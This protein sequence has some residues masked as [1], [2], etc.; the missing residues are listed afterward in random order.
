MKNKKT[1]VII[2]FITLFIPSFVFAQISQISFTTTNQIIEPDEISETITVQ[3]QDSGGNLAQTSET[4]DLEFLSSSLTG[5]FLSPSSENPVTTTMASGTANKNFRYRDSSE[6]TFTLTINAVGRVSGSTWSVSQDITVGATEQPPPAVSISGHLATSTTWSAGN[7]YVLEDIVTVPLGTTLTIEPGAIIKG[8]HG[9]AGKLEIFGTLYAQGS[10]EAPIYFTSYLDDEAGGDTD[11]TGTTTLPTAKDWVGVYFKS[12]STGT[13]DHVLV[14]Y[15][16]Y[17][18]AGSNS[19]IDNEGTLTISNSTISDNYIRGVFSSGSLTI[20]DSIFKNQQ[21]GIQTTAGVID[22]RNSTISNNSQYGLDLY[23]V[24][25]TTIINN[26]F[27]GNGKTARI[28]AS[29]AFIHSGNTSSDIEN[30]GFEMIGTVSGNVNWQSGDLPLIIPASSMLWISASSS[31]TINPGTVLKFGES[32]QIIVEGSLVAEGEK[33]SRIYFTSLKDD[34]LMGDTNGDASGT[35]ATM[36]DWTGIEF[37]IGATGNI[38]YSNIY[39]TGRFNGVTRAAVFN[40]GGEATLDNIEFSQNYDNDI[41]QSSGSTTVTNSIFSGINVYAVRHT[42][43]NDIDARLNWW[44]DSTGPTHTTNATGTGSN[45]SDK[46]TFDPWLKRD[47][48]LPNPVII[49]PGIASSYLVTNNN[50]NLEIW[51]N[52]SQMLVSITDSYLDELALSVSGSN[53]GV[54]ITPNGIIKQAG[55]SNFFEGLFEILNSVNSD[56]F[57]F[58]YDWRLDIKTLAF[59]LD[60][61][62]KEIKLQTGAD[63]VD[64]VAHSMGGLLAKEYL[65]NYGGAS[66]DK[67]IDLGTP[68]TGAPKAFK[69]LNYGD[70]FDASFLFGIFGL[71]RQKVK[72]ISQNMPSVYQ[73][74]PSESYFDESDPNYR[75]YVWNGIDGNDRLT[76]DETLV[77]M[78]AEGR[79]ELLLNRAQEFHEEVDG[80]NPSGYGVDT[81]NIVGCG[82]PTLGQFYILGKEGDKYIY[83]IKMINGDGTVPL[84][85]AEALEATETYYVKNAQ[86]ALMPSTSGVKELVASLLKDESLNI[87][88]YPNLAMSVSGCQIP[89]GKLVSFHSPIELHIYDGSGNHVGP[90]EN[91]DIVNEIDGVIYEVI[92]DNKFAYL[93]EGIEYTIKGSATD[94]GI[95]DTRIQEIVDG[96]VATT[97]IFADMPLTL[98]TQVSFDLGIEIPEQIYLDHDGDEVFETIQAISTTTDGLLESTGKLSKVAVEANA[99]SSLGAS[100]SQYVR[101]EEIVAT[102][103]PVAVASPPESTIQEG[104]VLGGSIVKTDPVQA[105][106][107]QQVELQ[108]EEVVYENTAVVYKSFGYKLVSFFKAIWAWFISKL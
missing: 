10:E 103:S 60:D 35:S 67:F 86:H 30:R 39:Y 7:I 72:E 107:E 51:M 68:H 80:L 56:T 95:F 12:G 74:L 96:E 13:L 55:T 89:N 19:G 70:N 20:T 29:T 46:I 31:L 11:G 5:E 75:Y 97:T 45:I 88:S 94:T 18:G 32:S 6:G 102:T 2:S 1:I 53:M 40:A 87:S 41:Y 43:G 98:N 90:D 52:I 17:I 23:G 62:I 76:F 81:Y 99:N 61:K 50:P 36:Q 48:T 4:I 78:K 71:N 63:N 26:I 106:E 16:G 15:A 33:N 73:L 101:K 100:N 85:S 57:E 66:V 77:Y 65:N 69:I 21:Y 54:S 25:S 64:I 79:N 59:D 91:G 34:S 92:D 47:P 104:R 108:K 42:G 82:T 44:G 84:R 37:R 27:S 38:S 58:S 49:V 24:N 83:N 14:R 93:P 105:E 3:T 9:G 22:I 8:R 28:D